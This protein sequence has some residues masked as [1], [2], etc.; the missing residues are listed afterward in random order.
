MTTA[1]RT[2]EGKTALVTGASRGIGRAIALGYARAGAH[3]ALL[4]RSGDA[5]REVAGEAQAHGVKTTVLTC[6]I[7]DPEAVERSFGQAVEMFG[8][9]DVLVN[10]AGH[11]GS[12]GPFLELTEQDWQTIMK[13][14]FD[15]M[16]QCLRLFG[17]HAVAR[18]SGSVVNISSV[19]GGNGCPMVSHYA[20]TKAAINSLSRSLA[21]EWAS[22]GVRV[23]VLAPGWVTTA[24]TSEFADNEEVSAGL[25]RA[26]PNGR[27]GEPED[28]VG[29]AVFLASDA[30]AMVTGA[31]LT[32]DGGLTAYHGGPTMLDLLAL[33]RIDAP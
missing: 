13:V 11:F 16:A 19:A 17:K 30:A 20:V 1:T 32:I 21:T 31:S 12:A 25:M 15:G 9:I 4:A 28:V 14:N 5:L 29:A 6:D 33:G 10:N 26:V 7:T 18:G 22:C 24:L 2:L 8:D 27:W 23:N 3:L